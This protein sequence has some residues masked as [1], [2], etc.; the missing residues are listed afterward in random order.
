MEI[1]V[2]ILLIP[3]QLLLELILQ[4]VL[5]ALAELGLHAVR[6]ALRPRKQASPVL[7][8]LGHLLLGAGAGGLSLLVFPQSFIHSTAGQTANLILTPLA[9]GGVMAAIGAWRRRRDKEPL[10][11]ESFA[12]GTAFALAMALVR[13][14]GTLP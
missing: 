1:L 5:E 2:E 12:Y 11:I 14:F 13:F 9:A 10:R 7:A 3:L 8:T 4:L 6:S